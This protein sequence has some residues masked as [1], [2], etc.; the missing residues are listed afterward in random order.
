MG[1]PG[2]S[3][4]APILAASSTA[5]KASRRPCAGTSPPLLQ[6]KP[7]LFLKTG[8]HRG[9]GRIGAEPDLLEDGLCSRATTLE[10]L[11]RWLFFI[12]GRDTV[13]LT[14]AAARVPGVDPVFAG[15]NVR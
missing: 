5:G 12:T 7:D 15:T 14:N 4:H 6:T 9:A 2:Q 1:R 13:S 11:R 3:V 8:G 10:G